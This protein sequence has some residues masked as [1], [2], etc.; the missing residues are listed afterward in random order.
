M[1]SQDDGARHAEHGGAFFE[2]I[3]VDFSTLERRKDIVN[4]DVLDAWYDPAPGVISTIQAH[5]PWLIRTSPPTHGEGLRAAIA[6]A[7][8]VQE[9][10]LVIG[11]G[12]SSLM[13][14]AFPRL[15]GRASRAVVLDPSY[16]EY[17]HLAE[18]VVGARTRRFKLDPLADFRIDIDALANECK[19][20]NLVIL[21]NPNSPNGAYVGRDAIVELLGKLNPSTKLWVDETYIDYAPDGSSAEPLV[22]EHDNLI[23]CKSMSKYYGLSGLRIGYLVCKPT[24]AAQWESLS[25]PWSVSLI[26]QVAAVAALDDNAYYKQMT[27][28][29]AELRVGLEAELKKLPGVKVFPSITNFLLMRLDKPV[30]ASVCQHAEKQGVFLRNCDSLSDRF[31]GHYIRTA[32]KDVEDNQKIIAALRSALEHTS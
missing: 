28:K 32:V 16:G 17:A 7:R 3:G 27:A 23:V 1:T 18:K 26:G 31:Q 8:G 22:A 2:A 30:A 24:L 4:A 20:A 10:Q 25:P 14:L 5:L 19:D 9:N 12:S 15:I 11:S 21:V 29:T 6:K 13:F